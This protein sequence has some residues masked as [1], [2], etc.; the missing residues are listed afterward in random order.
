M[1]SVEE[2]KLEKE[3]GLIFKHLGLPW[4]NARKEKVWAIQGV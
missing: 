2:S 3:E 1:N 4:K